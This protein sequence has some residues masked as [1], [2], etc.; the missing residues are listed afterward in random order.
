MIKSR[1]VKIT[2]VLVFIL[3]NAPLFAKTDTSAEPLLNAWDSFLNFYI[4]HD[5]ASPIQFAHEPLETLLYELNEYKKTDSYFYKDDKTLFDASR[6]INEMLELSEKAL[7]ACLQNDRELYKSYCEKLILCM[8]GFLTLSIKSS[9]EYVMPFV[10]LLAVISAMSLALIGGGAVYAKWQRE[11][12]RL[13]A[14]NERAL[15]ITK[16]I[17]QVQESERGRVSRELHDTVTQDTRTSLLYVHQLEKLLL[18]EKQTE[19]FAEKNDIVEKI[20]LLEERNMKNIRSIIRNLTPSEIEGADFILL[21]SELCVNQEELGGMPCK[22]HAEKSD[23]IKA[24]TAEQKLNTFRIVQESITNAIKHSDASEISVFVREESGSLVF[25]I[26]DDGKGLPSSDSQN[27]NFSALDT[28]IT[29]THLGIKGMK[30]RAAILNAKFEIKSS[31]ETG[32]QIKLTVP[33]KN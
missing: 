30:S 24:L 5:M 17:T 28:V 18:S 11:N 27:T 31:F 32:T 19:S 25:M 15:E 4:T 3:L 21:L 2:L 14:Q 7:S 29:G 26:C 33:L 13:I 12:E 8:N 22:F 10:I 1:C 9:K 23:L 6:K 20:K 16:T